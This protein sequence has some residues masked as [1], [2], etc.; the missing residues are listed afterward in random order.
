LGPDRSSAYLVFVATV[1]ITVTKDCKSCGRQLVLEVPDGITLR[2]D[3]I[4]YTLGVLCEDCAGKIEEAEQ[5][6][7]TQ[8]RVQALVE[9]SGIPDEYRGLTWEG[10]ELDE[11]GRVEAVKLAKEWVA[12]RLSGL[13]IGGPPGT[14][15]TRLAAT[16]SWARLHR[17]QRRED[18]NG[19]RTYPLRWIS[20]A[21]LVTMDK[22]GF[23][24]IEKKQATR[25][26]TTKVPLVLDDLDKV[27]LNENVKS[28]LFLAI[29][30]RVG[31]GVPLLV[32][33]NL[34]RDE[35]TATLG[36]AIASRLLG[37]CKAATLLGRDRRQS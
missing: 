19:W 3:S 25:I 10:M 7:E 27:P 16:A 14:G 30:K 13:L 23:G 18:D 36:S 4:A 12:G 6:V 1:P 21:E 17:V 35:F 28:L 9:S 29:D 33:T 20:V 2:P 5:G 32:T 8:A 34:P 37:Y 22:A 24:T 31:T 26:L 15:K 11:P